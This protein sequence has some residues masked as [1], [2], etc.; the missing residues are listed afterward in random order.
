MRQ[1]GRFAGRLLRVREPS[2]E[3]ENR[4]TFEVESRGGF[5]RSL[6]WISPGPLYTRKRGRWWFFTLPFALAFRF[7]F[8]NQRE[9]PEKRKPHTSSLPPPPPP[10]GDG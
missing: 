2:K 5:G 7:G 1:D 6:R 9:Q 4:F 10:F 8:R 3:Q